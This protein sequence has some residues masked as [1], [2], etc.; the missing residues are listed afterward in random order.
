MFILEKWAMKTI[1]FTK[2]K[3]DKL[4][5]L[6]STFRNIIKYVLIIYY[7]DSELTYGLEGYINTHTYVTVEP[8]RLQYIYLK[9]KL[10]YWRQQAKK[11]IKS[12]KKR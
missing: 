3:Q 2:I 4:T 9:T 6:K 1:H 11:N 7:M 8:V 5:F 12:K 10:D